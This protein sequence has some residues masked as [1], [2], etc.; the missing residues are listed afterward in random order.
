MD[1]V[2]PHAH[3]YSHSR[4]TPAPDP[5]FD[6]STWL[7]SFHSVNPD[8]LPEAA[9][10]PNPAMID[11]INGMYAQEYGY[12]QP[13]YGEGYGGYP[14]DEQAVMQY[15]GPVGPEFPVYSRAQAGS[16]GYHAQYQRRYWFVF[17]MFCIYE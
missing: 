8:F 12:T 17:A 5:Q 3:T 11:E 16:S 7:D 15:T 6:A 13:T 4:V 2:Q 9:L 10:P 1:S 14:A